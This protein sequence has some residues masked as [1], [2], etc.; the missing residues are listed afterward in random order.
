MRIEIDGLRYQTRIDLIP[1]KLYRVKFDR[2]VWPD[3]KVLSF[4]AVHPPCEVRQ[5]SEGDIIMF[6]GVKEFCLYSFLI[7]EK[8]YT[9]R[10]RLKTFKDN[11]DIVHEWIEGPL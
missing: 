8:V 5:L 9:L 3:A 6:L 4:V 10:S 2:K 11:H 7:N 1:G